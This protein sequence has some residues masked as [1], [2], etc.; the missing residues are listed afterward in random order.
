MKA[1]T[2]LFNAFKKG[3]LPGVMEHTAGKLFPYVYGTTYGRRAMGAGAYLAGGYLADQYISNLS[4]QVTAYEGKFGEYKLSALDK[5]NGFGTTAGMGLATL[6]LFGKDPITSAFKIP[7]DIASIINKPSKIAI[8]SAESNKLYGLLDANQLKNVRKTGFAYSEDIKRILPALD[9]KPE[10]I[11]QKSA[12]A[13]KS[14]TKFTKELRNRMSGIRPGTAGRFSMLGGTI[15]GATMFYN[16]QSVIEGINSLNFDAGLGSMAGTAIGGAMIGAMT[17]FNF[18]FAKTNSIKQANKSS[19][20]WGIGGAAIGALAPFT[21]AAAAIGTAGGALAGVGMFKARGGLG[22]T[23][24]ATGFSMLGSA[25]LGLIGGSMI[26]NPSGSLVPLGLFGGMLAAERLGST[27][28]G[29]STALA[30]SF[31]IT[32]IGAAA[33]GA[34]GIATATLHQNT[35]GAAEGRITSIRDSNTAMQRLNYSTAGLTLAL[36]RNRKAD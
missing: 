20:L 26:T 30:K 16:Q 21:S 18:G 34:M 24:G 2:S 5:L 7:G 9:L 29:A 6:A 28:L 25:S 17:G 32:A 19:A 14:H 33:G 13:A 10:L 3:D 15:A 12:Q 35:R 23:L 1:L 4:N 8:S 36:H 11:A 22:Q 27:K 31:E